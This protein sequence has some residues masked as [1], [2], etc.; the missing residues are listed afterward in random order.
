M[1]FSQFG[2][3]YMPYGNLAQDLCTISHTLSHK[4]CK[5][6]N[7]VLG[8]IETMMPII[9]KLESTFNPSALDKCISYCVMILAYIWHCYMKIPE[10]VSKNHVKTEDQPF[11]PS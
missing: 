5:S 10:I 2:S 4:S 9:S 8:S 11:L 3:C 7:D 6:N 1:S